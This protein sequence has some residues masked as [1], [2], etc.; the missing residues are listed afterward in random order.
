MLAGALREFAQQTHFPV[1]FGGF[2]TADGVRVSTVLGSRTRSLEGLIVRPDRGLGGRAVTE[3]RPRMT[4][5][6]GSSRQITHDYDGAVL[7]EGI[8]TLLAVPVLV[9]GRARGVLYGGSWVASTVGDV[10]A[11]PGF[12]IAETLATEL[13]V[14]EEVE[15]RMTAFGHIRSAPA[16]ARAGLDAQQ[17][18][19]LRASYAELRSI[20]ASVTDAA[21]RER[22]ASLEQRLAG[23]SGEAVVQDAASSE[24]TL[25]RR[26][27][28]VL[29]CAAIG[30]TNAEI[31]TTLALKEG[32]VKSYLQSAMSKLD[33]STRHAAVAKARRLGLLP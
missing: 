13:R 17:R 11:A 4:N 33:A 31:A 7:G 19:E 30:A 32:T 27:T 28:D 26:E 22:L 18:E 10:V 20:S 16:P 24:V 5:D 21:L 25:S 2:V 29:A 14:R 12:R 15:R 3:L 1:V 9:G 8:S 23:L 6:Y